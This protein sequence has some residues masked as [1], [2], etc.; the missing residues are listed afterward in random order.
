MSAAK[1]NH[2]KLNLKVSKS[3]KTLERLY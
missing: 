3:K 2:S 1:A